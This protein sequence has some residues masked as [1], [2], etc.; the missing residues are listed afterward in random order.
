[1]GEQRE[2]KRYNHFTATLLSS[3]DT[4]LLGKA[5]YILSMQCCFL[6]ATKFKIS[7]KINFSFLRNWK[8]NPRLRQRAGA[9]EQKQR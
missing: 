1:M 4:I 8:K 9:L 5:F 2:G 3:L 7:F 6:L